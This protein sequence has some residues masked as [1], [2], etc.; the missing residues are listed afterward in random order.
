[1]CLVE[2]TG[3]KQSSELTLI[4]NYFSVAQ[5]GQRKIVALRH[6]RLKYNPNSNRLC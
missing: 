1:M 4:E 6:P 2:G 3:A 5:R